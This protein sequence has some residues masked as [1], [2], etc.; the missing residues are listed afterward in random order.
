MEI[1]LYRGT[2]QFQAEL[3]VDEETGEIADD[4]HLEMLVKRNPVGTVAYILQSAANAEMIDAHIKRMSAKKAA[5]TRNAARAKEQLMQVMKFTGVLS[6]KSDDGTFS[7]KLE[8]ERDSSVDPFEPLLIPH[9]Y[10]REIPAT[11]EPNKALI[12]NAIKEGIDVSGARL[13]YA[14]RLTLK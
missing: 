14:D 5:I 11:F 1:T 9:R 10:M 12:K 6:I 8:H 2:E 4:G 3:S 13:D 7:A